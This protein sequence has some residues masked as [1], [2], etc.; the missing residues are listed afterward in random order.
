M[1]IGP[2]DVSC[3]IEGCG[4]MVRA[5][6]GNGGFC[7][8]HAQRVRRYGNPH[9]VT[10]EDDRR[11][12]SRI[13]QPKLGKAKPTTYK[14][15]LGRHLRRQVAEQ[16]L[17]RPLRD[18]EIVHHIDGDRHNN[19]PSNLEVLIDQGYHA[20]RHNPHGFNPRRKC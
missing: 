15:Y 6:H 19:D 2:P 13:A 14:K 18:G 10:S 1:R 16:K 17:G 9:H 12:L 11:L 20:L 7:G 5:S 4:R 3:S 8:K